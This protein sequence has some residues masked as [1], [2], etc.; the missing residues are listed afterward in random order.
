MSDPGTTFTITF[1]D[2]I[3]E[4]GVGESIDVR[5]KYVRFLDQGLRLVGCW[6]STVFHQ[7]GEEKTS[8]KVGTA[9]FPWHRIAEVSD[10]F[11]EVEGLEQWAGDQGLSFD[12]MKK[13]QEAFRLYG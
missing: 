7:D 4:E 5:G 8:F 12:D 6:T 10:T 9:F 13:D 1:N 3:T 2:S 11:E